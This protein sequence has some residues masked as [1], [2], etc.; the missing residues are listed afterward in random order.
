MPQPGVFARAWFKWK[1]LRLPWRKT[2][3]VGFDLSGNTFWEFKDALNTNRMRRIVK[4][5]NKTPHYSDVKVTRQSWI[6]L[7]TTSVVAY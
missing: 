1:T 4:Y 6:L 3:L 7:L 5:N 2:F